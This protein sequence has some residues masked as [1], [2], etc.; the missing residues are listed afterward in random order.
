VTYGSCTTVA[1]NSPRIM[2][3]LLELLWI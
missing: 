3:V 1:S 2:A